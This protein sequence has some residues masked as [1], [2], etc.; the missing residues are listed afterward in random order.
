MK[1]RASSGFQAGS[2]RDFLLGPGFLLQLGCV[3]YLV[4][5]ILDSLKNDSPTPTQTDI[6]A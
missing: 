3:C 6:D 5:D 2:N 4:P 1:S